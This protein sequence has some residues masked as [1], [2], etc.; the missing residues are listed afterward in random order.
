MPRQTSNNSSPRRTSTSTPTIYERKISST[1]SRGQQSYSQQA[2]EYQGPS[3][4]SSIKQGIGLGMG[5]EIGHRVVNS[6]LG[7]S[8]VNQVSQVSQVNQ[9]DY[10]PMESQ[11]IYK[12]CLEK[13][14]EFP[15]ICKP[16]Q[17]KDKSLW[18]ACMEKNTFNHLECS[19]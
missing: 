15:E 18:K 11:L 3:I 1:P 6:F 16:F 7:P 12:Q 10:L 17:T 2:V 8:Q 13:N 5:S 19:Q 14:K 4:F 9:V